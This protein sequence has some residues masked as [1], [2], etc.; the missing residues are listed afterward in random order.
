MRYDDSRYN[1]FNVRCCGSD[2]ELRPRTGL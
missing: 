2:M 1:I